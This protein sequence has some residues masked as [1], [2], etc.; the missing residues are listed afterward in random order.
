MKVTL[1]SFTVKFFLNHNNFFNACK[2]DQVN[3]EL[4]F[5]IMD[6]YEPLT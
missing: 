2:I 1:M 4:K 3:S 5:V 6:L